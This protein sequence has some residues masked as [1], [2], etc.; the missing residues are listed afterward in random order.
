MRPLYTTELRENSAL[1]ASLASGE[2][3]FES[4]FSQSALLYTKSIPSTLVS[5]VDSRPRVENLLRKKTLL[6]TIRYLVSHLRTSCLPEPRRKH[7]YP[8]LTAGKRTRTQHLSNPA[9]QQ[10]NNPHPKTIPS[11]VHRRSHCTYKITELAGS[12]IIQLLNISIKVLP[13]IS[14]C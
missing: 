3:S 6:S 14:N 8:G 11:S 12:F 13:H 10:P 7:S 9:T 4:L 5:K 1:D 2:E